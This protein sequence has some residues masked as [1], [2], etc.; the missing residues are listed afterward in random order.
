MVAKI[1]EKM[2]GEELL[3]LK[4]FNSNSASSSVDAELD[5]RAMPDSPLSNNS[6][7]FWAGRN[8]AMRHSSRMAA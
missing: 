4:I 5:R 1:L 8:F 2:I 7:D 6:E 3:L